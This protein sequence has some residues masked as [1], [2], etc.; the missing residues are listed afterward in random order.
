MQQE[1]AAAAQT[2][3]CIAPLPSCEEATLCLLQVLQLSCGERLVRS[4]AGPQC[5]QPIHGPQLD[6]SQQLQE[7]TAQ[8]KV[9]PVLDFIRQHADKLVG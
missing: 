8:S 2:S 5:V 9:Q 6:H 7:C 4:C 1:A 3:L